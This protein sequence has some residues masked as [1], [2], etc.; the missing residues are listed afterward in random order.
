MDAP[1]DEAEL[2]NSVQ[3]ESGN[4][5]GLKRKGRKDTWDD[6]LYSLD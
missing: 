4:L 5:K 3:N 6:L 1:S 2:L